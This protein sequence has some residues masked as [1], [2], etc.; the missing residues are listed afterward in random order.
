M[1]K[2]FELRLINETLGGCLGGS[3]GW[4]GEVDDG[5]FVAFDKGCQRCMECRVCLNPISICLFYDLGSNL[6]WRAVG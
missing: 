2:I 1:L 5:V 4:S 3:V 6:I